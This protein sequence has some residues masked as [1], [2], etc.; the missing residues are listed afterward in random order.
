MRTRR[1]TLAVPDERGFPRH[2]EVVLADRWQPELGETAPDGDSTFRIVILS[3]PAPPSARVLTPAVVV[4]AP[5]RRVDAPLAI[6]EP[7]ATYA[8]EGR[9]AAPPFPVFSPADM[10]S[11]AEGRILAATPPRVP[12]IRVF[13]AQKGTPRLEL[14]AQALLSAA[15]AA[16]NESGDRFLAALASA[17]TAPASPEIETQARGKL[18][19]KLRKTLRQAD[20]KLQHADEES[21][22]SLA[23]AVGNLHFVAEA[24]SADDALTEAQRIFAE[25]LAFAEAVFLCRRLVADPPSA[26]ELAEMRAY[27]AAAAIPDSTGDLAVDR[28]VT[29][30]QLS[31]AALFMEPH[32]FDGMRATF[33]YF[34]KRF[35]GAYRD[36]HRRYWDG[37]GRLLEQIEEAEATAR[38]LIRLNSISDLGKPVG[39]NALAQYQD[40]R[41][42]LAGCP[43]D[44]ALQESLQKTPSCPM[45]AVTLAE[46]PPQPAVADVSRRLKRALGQQQSR[47]S[48][49]AIRRILSQQKGERI[50][51]FLQVVQASDL[52]GLAD[53]LDDET[54]AFLRTLLAS[55]GAESPLLETLLRAHPEVSEES[56]EAAVE[57][58]R[59]LLGEQ[60]ATQRRSDPTRPP[61][62]VLDPRAASKARR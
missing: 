18:I 49:A 47:L 28:R 12:A 42:S 25:P 22:A 40:M 35:I 15:S 5:S 19:A 21:A 51:Q 16:G 29:L 1:F 31:P 34:R 55:T 11:Y 59:R 46:E 58:F 61:R 36:H 60:L 23:R 3:Q 14:L 45:C 62:V 37:C 2:G 27:L 17:L 4:C 20:V 24:K 52:R 54:V 41:T 30:E 50:E 33:E 44:E 7:P 57:E 13:P 43:L 39:L 56:L 32:R 26:L 48:T 6:R 38:A 10:A 53:V 9:A 8:V